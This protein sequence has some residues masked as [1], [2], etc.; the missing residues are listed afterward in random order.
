MY[1]LRSPSSTHSLPPSVTGTHGPS[2]TLTLLPSIPSLSVHPSI[3]VVFLPI[4]S[5]IHS[6][7][8]HPHT[9]HFPHPPPRRVASLCAKAEGTPTAFCAPQRAAATKKGEWPPQ[10]ALRPP[11]CSA[12]AQA[13]PPSP[14]YLSEASVGVNSCQTPVCVCFCLSQAVGVSPSL[15]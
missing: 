12:L 15:W 5:D 4:G 11:P 14:Q 13:S 6:I 3:L 10:K 9:A 2:P 1:T 8:S 7:V